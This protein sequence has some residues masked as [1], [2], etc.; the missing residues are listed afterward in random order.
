NLNMGS[1]PG[2]TGLYVGHCTLQ[3]YPTLISTLNM[4]AIT[5]E[6]CKL[7]RNYQGNSGLHPNVWQVTGATNS[8]FRFN[9][10]TEGIMMDFISTNDAPNDGWDIYGNVWHDSIN[11][12]YGRILETQYRAQY[13][14]R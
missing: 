5:I 10:V 1:G 14:I 12:W 9:E 6:H 3:G 11:G 8:I 7:W 2:G 4:S 13:R